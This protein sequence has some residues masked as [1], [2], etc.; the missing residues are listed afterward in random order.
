MNTEIADASKSTPLHGVFKGADIIAIP[1]EGKL[2]IPL[3]CIEKGLEY[4]AK[5][6]TN[7]LARWLDKQM[8]R[9]LVHVDKFTN[10]RL[11]ALKAVGGDQFAKCAPV[12]GTGLQN[13]DQSIMGTRTPAIWMVTEQ[14]LYRILMLS[15]RPSAIAF[16]DW[17]ES[18][19]LPTLNRTGTYTMPSTPAAAPLTKAAK[20]EPK[21]L[22]TPARDPALVKAEHDLNQR[23]RAQQ[24]E[25]I[26]QLLAGVE[27]EMVKIIRAGLFYFH[28]HDGMKGVLEVLD[29]MSKSLSAEEIQML[30]SFL[31]ALTRAPTDGLPRAVRLGLTLDMATRALGYSDAGLLALASES[32][33]RQEPMKRHT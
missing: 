14:G 20:P 5:G 21:V 16:Q 24:I 2:W 3:S 32:K 7:Q 28:K 30:V 33:G 18:E 23:V 9:Q 26:T 11:A 25:Q 8:V 22:P 19:L 1:F 6:L 29:M 15:K 13:A 31:R 4:P 10:G 27:D 12:D 17:L